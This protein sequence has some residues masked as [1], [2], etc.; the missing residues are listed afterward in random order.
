M[1]FIQ[2]LIGMLLG[3]YLNPFRNGFAFRDKTNEIMGSIF[4]TIVSLFNKTKEEETEDDEEL[5]KTHISKPPEP[6][7]SEHPCPSCGESMIIPNDKAWKGYRI[8][9]KCS[10]VDP[11]KVGA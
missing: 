4:G 5:G 3:W 1:W 7:K 8:C 11:V 10:K 2:I 9:A 6:I